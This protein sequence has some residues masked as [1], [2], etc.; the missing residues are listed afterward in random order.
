MNPT[1]SPI[2]EWLLDAVRDAAPGRRQRVLVLGGLTAGVTAQ[3]ERAVGSEGEVTV[4]PHP[5]DAGDAATGQDTLSRRFDLVFAAPLVP[6]VPAE[7]VLAAAYQAL[8]PGGRLLLD[9]PAAAW[10]DD[11]WRLRPLLGELGMDLPAGVEEEC[12]RREAERMRV[13]DL[14]LAARTCLHVLTDA[15]ELV[16]LAVRAIPTAAPR[17]PD[18]LRIALQE[19]LARR[20]PPLQTV[21]RRIRLSARR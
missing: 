5:A 4:A 12:L 8:R 6:M 18:A 11:L 15:N 9:L 14:Q 19:L 10:S 7:A 16:D 21:L 20:P 2:P 13:R 17:D 3:F 1:A